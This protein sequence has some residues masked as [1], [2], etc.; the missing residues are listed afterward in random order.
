[1]TETTR[2]LINPGRLIVMGRTPEGRNFVSYGIFGNHPFLR[3]TTLNYEPCLDDVLVGRVGVANKIFDEISQDD[4]SNLVY[5]CIFVLKSGAL[6]VGN[7]RQTGDIYRE[8]RK[9]KDIKDV[10]HNASNK[11][12]LPY[13]YTSNDEGH[14]KHF[15]ASR[16][17]GIV[18][19]DYAGFG[20]LF[21]HTGEKNF[22]FGYNYI[23]LKS[24]R[25]SLLPVYS[26]VNGGI[27]P[28]FTGPPRSLNLI[29]NSAEGINDF[30][31]KVFEPPNWSADWNNDLRIGFASVVHGP[32]TDSQ[33]D[34][35]VLER[36][37]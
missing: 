29:H 23:E 31:F 15:L 9:N 27:G 20:N 11:Q 21:Y 33:P 30:F 32:N 28:I 36:E 22:D 18:S 16:I 13:D 8:L 1:M 25:A 19:G 4:F 7:G 35:A 3:N 12:G 37:Y 26:L 14:T 10:L 17:S 6:V 24:G 34:V 5:D 2:K